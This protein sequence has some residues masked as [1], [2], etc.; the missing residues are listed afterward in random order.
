MKR[1]GACGLM[2]AVGTLAWAQPQV[3]VVGLFNGAAVVN[4][5]C[6]RKLLKVGQRLDDVEVVSADAQQAVLRIDGRTQTFTLDREYSDGYST[7]QRR[8]FS[9]PRSN[10]G[11]YQV[12]ASINGR[13]VALLV[14]TGATSVALSGAQADQLG[15]R[16]RDG[17]PGWVETA[18]GHARA[19][20]TTLTQVRLGD[21]EVVGVEAMVLEGNYPSQGL[22]GMSFLNR[23]GWREAQGVLYV[24][25]R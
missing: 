14:D 16:Y 23:V 17:T 8:E 6:Q 10:N 22:L 4:V 9:I 3:R 24:Q 19:W 18:S 1:L 12:T 25:A 2:L 13:P 15:I 7:P 11:H 21:V 5:N 20:R